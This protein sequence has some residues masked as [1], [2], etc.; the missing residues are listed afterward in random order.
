MAD[1]QSKVAKRKGHLDMLI[2]LK[3]QLIPLDLNGLQRYAGGQKARLSKLTTL[4]ADATARIEKVRKAVAPEVP[5]LLNTGARPDNIAEYLEF[6][7]GCIVGS[8]LKV[9]GDTW[10]R[11]DP[12]RAKVFVQ[13]ARAG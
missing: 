9:G 3:P 7:D 6:A 5:V 11:V 1:D 4:I 13:A 10:N 2:E 12:Q 8:S